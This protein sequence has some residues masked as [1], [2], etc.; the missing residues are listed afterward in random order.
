MSSG[1]PGLV[2][3]YFQTR[4]PYH[5]RKSQF[6]WLYDIEQEFFLL[7]GYKEPVVERL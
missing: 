1:Y 6:F 7:A 3:E 4:I 2:C 5:E